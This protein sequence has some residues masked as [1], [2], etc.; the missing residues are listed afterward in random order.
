MLNIHSIFEIFVLYF[1]CLFHISN[2]YSQFEIFV[3]Y[4]KN[5]CYISNICSVLKRLYSLLSLFYTS[6]SVQCFKYSFCISNIRSSC[7]IFILINSFYPNQG[8]LLVIFQPFSNI[9]CAQH[10]GGYLEYF[11]KQVHGASP[12]ADCKQTTELMASTKRRHR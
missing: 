9:M 12:M 3:L 10:C 1:K 6:I 7:K 8:D 2:I 5:L 11:G 4:P